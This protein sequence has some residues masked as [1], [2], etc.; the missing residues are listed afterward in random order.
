MPTSE[1]CQ[2]TINFDIDY[3]ITLAETQPD[4]F[5]TQQST[6]L[7]SMIQSVPAEL[8]TR[9]NGLKWR[10]EMEIR[11][12]KTPQESRARIH[13][14]LTDALYGPDGLLESIMQNRE[15]TQ[16]ND[17]NRSDSSNKVSPMPSPNNKQSL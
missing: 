16:N 7:A 14:I 5:K 8:Q 11:Q 2:S 13:R 4:Q 12:A 1:D 15:Q 6:A 10:V 17:A 9:L 3:W